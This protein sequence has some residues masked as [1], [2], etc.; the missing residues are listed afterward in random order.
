[1]EAKD[2]EQFYEFLMGLNEEFSTMKT[3]ILSIKP[4]MSLRAVYHL[5]S[6]GKKQ[7]H[8]FAFRRTNHETMAFQVQNVKNNK[9]ERK[10]KPRRGHCQKLG[11]TNDKCYEIICYPS[12]WRKSNR[13]TRRD[14]GSWNDRCN[15]PKVAWSHAY[16]SDETLMRML[17]GEM[18]EIEG[19]RCWV[20]KPTKSEHSL[21]HSMNLNYD[22]VWVIDS[23]AN[24]HIICEDKFL[25]NERSGTYLLC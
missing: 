12:N 13:A 18:D 16:T 6:E 7:R 3:H 14:R 4:L 25:L 2:K 11:H 22:K 10:E 9:D 5:A 20:I 19:S 17:N 21:N 24:E 15:G 8:I 23:R 1:M